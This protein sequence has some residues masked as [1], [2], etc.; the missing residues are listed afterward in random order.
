MFGSGIFACGKGDAAKLHFA[1]LLDSH[2][3]QLVGEITVLHKFVKNQSEKLPLQ[4]ETQTEGSIDA[5]EPCMQAHA[6]I[7]SGRARFIRWSPKVDAVIRNEGPVSFQNDPLEFPVFRACFPEVIYMRAK[8]A[9]LL[10][11]SCQQRGSGF[12]Q[13]VFSANF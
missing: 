7:F 5:H 3:K 8:K 10:G 13:S 11:V 6:R 1:V 12:H 9:P 4:A 2:L